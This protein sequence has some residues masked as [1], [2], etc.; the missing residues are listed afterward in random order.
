[1]VKIEIVLVG[2]GAT[3]L[4]SSVGHS[5]ESHIAVLYFSII[6]V[7]EIYEWHKYTMSNNRNHLNQMIPNDGT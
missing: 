5:P 6:W 2:G 4:Q 1:M 3:P 7:F